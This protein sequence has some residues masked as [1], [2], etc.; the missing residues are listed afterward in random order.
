MHQCPLHRLLLFAFNLGLFGY[1]LLD[2][3]S[4][5]PRHFDVVVNVDAV[6]SVL[7]LVF[8][9]QTFKLS[10]LLFVVFDILYLHETFLFVNEISEK[11][12]KL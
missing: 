1:L 11:V 10:H 4:L 2:A 8:V 7:L 6:Q 12:A 9:L 5:V 3:L